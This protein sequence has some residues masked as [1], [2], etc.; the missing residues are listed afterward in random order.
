MNH[1]HNITKITE[2]LNISN[3]LLI[4]TGAGVSAESGFPTFRGKDGLWNQTEIQKMATP[5]GFRN[6]P[7]AVWEWYCWRRELVLKGKPNP[8]HYAIADLEKLFDDFL[9]A[10][11]NV[12]NLHRLAGNE[13][14]M[15][16]HGNIFREKCL[17]CDFNRYSE[18]IYST[19]PN[20]PD[21]GEL[22]RPDVVWFGE[23]LAPDVISAVWS[24]SR[25]ADCIMVVGTSAVVYPCAELPFIVKRNDGK[26]IEVNLDA[27]PISSIADVSI[28]GK[29]GEIL[30][31]I[32]E[33]Y[34]QTQK[35]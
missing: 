33:K 17:S 14:V 15:E 29:S 6:D 21:C 4:L 5:D 25:Q 26:V 11:Q 35:K 7:V 16:L 10:T 32:V 30:P 19:P 22:L 24:F 31:E 28:R 12:D 3:K 8:G 20:C 27:T 1:S 23:S 34:K 18:K 9:L 2:I 13:K